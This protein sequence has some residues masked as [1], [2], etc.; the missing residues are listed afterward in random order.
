MPINITGKF[1]SMAM[2]QAMATV[3]AALVALAQVPSAKAAD[4]AAGLW[5][6]HTGRGAVEIAPCASGLCGYIVWLKDSND[7]HGRPLHD[8]LNDDPKKRNRPICGLQVMG[9]LKP[10]S[11]GS[12]DNGWIYDPE[13]G[14]AFDLELRMLNADNLQVKGY[15]GVKFLNETFKWRR[16]TTLPS[17][18]CGQ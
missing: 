12:W 13:K 1:T 7:K 18:R 11:D 14:E 15:K 9:S 10:Q 5:Y 3:T 6:D 2:S 16:V 8:A 4:Q 17:A